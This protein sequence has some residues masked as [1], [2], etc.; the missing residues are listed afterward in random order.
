MQI[1]IKAKNKIEATIPTKGQLTCS[2][3]YFSC[4]INLSTPSK[5]KNFISYSKNIVTFYSKTL[6]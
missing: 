6:N 4:F 3:V 2:S 5:F 1:V